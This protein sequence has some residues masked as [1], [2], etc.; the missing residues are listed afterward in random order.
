MGMLGV[1]QFSAIINPGEAAILAVGATVQTPVVRDGKIV[2]R[3]IM[4]ITVSADHR[5][6]DGTKAAQFAN[7]IKSKLEDIQLW[8]RLTS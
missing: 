2:V 8:K 4:K 7:A 3:A 1:E 6:V 5:I